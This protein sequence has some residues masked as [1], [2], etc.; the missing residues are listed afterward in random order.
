MDSE[1]LTGM[2]KTQKIASVLIFLEHYHKDGYKFLNHIVSIIGTETRVSFV[3]V[4][5]KELSK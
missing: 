5:T 2:Y 3:N 1:M 4:K